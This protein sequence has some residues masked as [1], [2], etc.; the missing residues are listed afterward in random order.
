MRLSSYLW[1]WIAVSFAARL[2]SEDRNSLHWL[3]ASFL[4][5]DHSSAG[6]H[7][8]RG[9]STCHSRALNAILAHSCQP[10]SNSHCRPL[11]KI[12]VSE[13]LFSNDAYILPGFGSPWSFHQQ[14]YSRNAL[15]I[16]LCPKRIWIQSLATLTPQDFRNAAQ[17]VC[18]LWL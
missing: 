14:P 1:N 15:A 2:G 17:E 6:S 16:V 5:A 13:L 7:V 10:T 11:Y 12:P 4:L 18:H 3:S 8:L 9:Q